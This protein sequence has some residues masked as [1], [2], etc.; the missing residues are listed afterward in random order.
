MSSSPFEEM[1]KKILPAIIAYFN[2]SDRKVYRQ[3]DISKILSKNQNQWHTDIF[4]SIRSFIKYLCDHSDMKKVELVFGINKT[5]KETRYIWGDASDYELAISLRNRSYLTHNSAAYLH[6]LTT[7]VP[8]TIYINFEQSKRPVTGILSQEAINTAFR[9]SVRVSGYT[10]TYDDKTICLL[11]GM[12]TGQL[13]VIELIGDKGE[14]LHLTGIERTLIDVSVR[15]IYSGGVAE[16]LNIYRNAYPKVS[17]K[18]LFEVYKKMGYIYPY[19]QVIG[20]YLDQAGVYG[21]TD[22]DLFHQIDMPFNFYLTHKMGK[23]SFSEKWRLYY[24]TEFDR[25]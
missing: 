14:K 24:P 20:F 8:K 6:G 12:Y 4:I 10:A 23:T 11:N 16:V 3:S 7:S 13:G 22:V 2:E 18:R 9:N 19:H 17:V 25:D 15:P 21:E 5:R 1:F